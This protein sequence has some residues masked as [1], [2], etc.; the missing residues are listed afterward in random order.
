M[1]YISPA[2]RLSRKNGLWLARALPMAYTSPA[3]R[4]SRQNGLWLARALPMAYTS[5]AERLSRQYG[6]WHARALPMAYSVDL[7]R[8]P[9]TSHRDADGAHLAGGALPGGNPGCGPRGDD[10]R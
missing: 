2:E 1:A 7:R 10:L 6:L 8:G 5:P 3:E 9:F 4:L